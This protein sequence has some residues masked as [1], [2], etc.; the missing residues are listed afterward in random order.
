MPRPV[1]G[2]QDQAP[3][4]GRVGR[5]APVE[6][7]NGRA[8]APHHG[9][10]R[11]PHRAGDGPQA[12]ED[13]GR[14]GGCHRRALSLRDHPRHEGRAV[15]QH[16]QPHREHHDRDDHFDDGE[17]LFSFHYRTTLPSWLTSTE[18]VPYDVAPVIRTVV[19]ALSM[20]SPRG[21]N[22][23]ESLVA[24]SVTLYRDARSTTLPIVSVAAAL[25]REQAVTQTVPGLEK[26]TAARQPRCT[27]TA[28]AVATAVPRYTRVELTLDVYIARRILGNP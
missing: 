19:S 16:Q 25:V 23:I 3:V 20:F 13:A 6:R 15:H 28:R 21:S 9:R 10:A 11:I 1:F 2:R 17:P 18:S 4:I 27:A 5:A 8:A 22:R 7:V 12:V 14:V 26:C 24:A